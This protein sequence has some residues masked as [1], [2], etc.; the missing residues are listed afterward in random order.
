MLGKL[1]Y[2]KRPDV[3]ADGKEDPIVGRGFIAE[4]FRHLDIWI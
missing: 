2:A 4:S 1:L 3:L